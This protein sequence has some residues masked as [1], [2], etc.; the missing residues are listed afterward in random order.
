M[1]LQPAMFSCSLSYLA[2]LHL[3][4]CG[5]EDSHPEFRM[6][7]GIPDG[8][9]KLIKLLPKC[10]N[11]VTT[12]HFQRA[13]LASCFSAHNLACVCVCSCCVW[14]EREKS[15]VRVIRHKQLLLICVWYA[16][17]QGV[18]SLPEIYIYIYIY[19]KSTALSM[20]KMKTRLTT[21]QVIMIGDWSC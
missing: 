5:C 6:L 8:R 7:P 16:P 12:C 21:R 18:V 2:A 11:Q 17:C 10:F 19:K 13:Q 14:Q 4:F 20:I 1:F 3:K 15:S 9:I